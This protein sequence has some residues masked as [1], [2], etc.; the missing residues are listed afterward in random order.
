MR[1]KP[2]DE[3][4]AEKHNQLETRIDNRIERFAPAQI[5]DQV[6]RTYEDLRG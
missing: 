4:V 6:K 3:P 1:Y 2:P 5:L